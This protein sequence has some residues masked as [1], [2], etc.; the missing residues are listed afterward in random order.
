MI[1]LTL[2]FLGLVLIIGIDSTY[3]NLNSGMY[4]PILDP[5]ENINLVYALL[6]W[7]TIIITVQLLILSRPD[8]TDSNVFIYGLM[9]GFG[10]Y[11][12]YNFTNAATYPS[13]WSN[14]IIIGDTLWG[15]VLTGFIAWCLYKI[16]NLLNLK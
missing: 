7:L 1:N 14:T 2:T 10:T 5:K 12:L 6:A 13:K 16:N 4:L 9:L 15:M 3:L 11:A 8:V